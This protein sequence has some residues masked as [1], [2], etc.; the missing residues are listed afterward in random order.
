MTNH[1]TLT[2]HFIVTYNSSGGEIGCTL[3]DIL[4]FFSGTDRIPPMGF[5]K[6]PTLTF[7]HDAKAV[8]PTAST[9]DIQLRLPTRFHVYD[10]FKQH[11]L[12]GLK[13]H[14]GF[15]GI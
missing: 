9:C 12:L 14:D 2:L 5:E 10:D 1:Y 6:Y 8:L 15:G 3:E 7:I 13:G 4:V 11:M